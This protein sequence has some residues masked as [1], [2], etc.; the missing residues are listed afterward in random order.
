MDVP[1]KAVKAEL[2]DIAIKNLPEKRYETDEA[3][4]K[5]NVDILRLP[6]KHCLLNPVELA[7]AGLKQYVRDNNVNFRLSDVRH[8]AQEWMLNLKTAT[9]TAYLNHVYN[10]EEMFKKS[11]AFT[12]QLQE[13]LLDDDNHDELDF[14]IEEMTD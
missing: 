13:D 9:V 1:G 2:L 12:E 3:V 5:Y 6:I 7:W 14:E 11:D 8:L 10:V 4:K